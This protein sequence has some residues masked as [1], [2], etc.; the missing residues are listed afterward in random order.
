MAASVTPQDVAASR[1]AGALSGQG[2]GGGGEGGGGLLGSGQTGN[3]GGASGGGQNTTTSGVQ[4][5][6][7]QGP[8]DI[9][10]RFGTGLGIA[11]SAVPF[12]GGSLPLSGLGGM[13][14]AGRYQGALNQAGIQGNINPWSAGLSSI[15]ASIGIPF[16]DLNLASA[17]GM[18]TARQ[19]VEDALRANL[20]AVGPNQWNTSM[21]EG[22]H[23]FGINEANARV[24]PVT[25]ESS[26]YASYPAG[27]MASE[28]TRQSLNEDVAREIARNND[29]FGTPD[30]AKGAFDAGAWG[31]AYADKGGT[32]PGGS[33]GSASDKGDT[34]ASPGGSGGSSGWGGDKG[35]TSD[36]DTGQYVRG[37]LIGAPPSAGRGAGRYAAGGAVG[38]ANITPRQFGTLRGIDPPGPDD[39]IGALQTGEGVMTR[40]SMQKYPGLLNAANKGTLN[41]TH[42]QGLLA[43]RPKARR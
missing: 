15:A 33:T 1:G 14:D 37:G 9:N 32:D 3:V 4:G 27:F 25:R 31:G 35:G 10:S 23:A 42:V 30:V 39:Q 12:P 7:A 20:A 2:G 38:D 8:L 43:P 6:Y 36:R 5:V 24:D 34:S 18:P 11:G 28:L 22:P 21:Y 16:T 41:P 19:Q 17:F 40:A 29:I 26:Q 13:I